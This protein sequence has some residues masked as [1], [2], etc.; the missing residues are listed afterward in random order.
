MYECPNCSANLKYHINKQA[1]YCEHCETT[2]DPYSF[3]K[4][5]D[6][7]E[8]TE[9]E[10]TLFT[11]P[12]CG[13]EIISED[14][15]AATF[16]S[17]C[18]S[19]T[20]LD[21]RI[22]RERRPD[23]IIPFAKTEVSCRN[24]YKKMLK[25][26]LFAPDALKDESHIQKFRGIYM[27]YWVYSFEKK[28][29]ATFK[30]SKDRRR[31][32]YIITSHYDV[33]CDIDAEYKGISFDA[34]STFCDSLSNAIAP[35]DIKKSKP[36]TPAFL[37]G[38]YADI[39]DVGK[40]RYKSDATDIVVDVQKDQFA[41]TRA[42]SKYNITDSQHMSSFKRSLRADKITIERALFPVWFLSYRKDDRVAYAVVNGQTGKVAA[43]LPVDPKKYLLGSFILAVPLFLL[44]NLLFT[45]K[46]GWLLGLVAILSLLCTIIS[47]V[48]LTRIL[49]RESGDDDKGKTNAAPL[50]KK[51]QTPSILQNRW[52]KILIMIGACYLLPIIF[53]FTIS[54]FMLLGLADIALKLFVG[55][56]IVVALLPF[57]TLFTR[58]I[59][60]KERD[61]SHSFFGDWKRKL[62]ILAKPL[63]GILIAILILIINPV[64]DLFYYL[65]AIACMGM[66]I[67]GVT[68]IMKQHNVLSTRKPPQLN[69]RGGDEVE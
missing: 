35:F 67:W 65:G 24:A 50:Q 9:Y 63:S 29:P 46:P 33:S 13:G 34:S 31:G 19:S 14:T 61:T 17:Y 68:D 64:S 66:I 44:L 5:Q 41:K 49:R 21:S 7:E 20:I 53:F 62:P 40:S 30:G 12:Q 15:T 56:F 22:S 52:V 58:L 47:N 59:R 55:F 37:S 28:G 45:L 51:T 36:F 25:Q 4:E 26:A 42:F 60:K 1:L 10:V 57:F 39:A 8:S 23:Y 48:Q 27:P 16:C 43:D 18:G 69:R 32:D 2:V 54:P 3:H 11:C 6:A 38:F